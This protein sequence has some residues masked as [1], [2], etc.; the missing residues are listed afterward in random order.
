[1]WVENGSVCHMSSS[2][3]AY[4]G[5]YYSDSDIQINVGPFRRVYSAFSAFHVLVNL[6]FPKNCLLSSKLRMVEG[7]IVYI[8]CKLV[9]TNWRHTFSD[10]I[11]K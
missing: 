1:M 11:E 10:I 5:L 9:R 7:S 2:S 4:T 6:D 8:S 3:N